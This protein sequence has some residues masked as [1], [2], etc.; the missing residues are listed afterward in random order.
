MQYQVP[1][2]RLIRFA[3]QRGLKK[4]NELD[5]TN[6]ALST[7]GI[8]TKVT[9]TKNTVFAALT[10]GRD[11]I[12]LVARGTLI[13][14]RNAFAKN[15]RVNASGIPFMSGRPESTKESL[16][17]TALTGVVNRQLSYFDEIDL[18]REVAPRFFVGQLCTVLGQTY[19]KNGF[20]RYMPALVTSSLVDP[21]FEALGLRFVGRGADLQLEISP[22]PQ[23]LYAAVTAGQSRVYAQTRLF[24]RAFRDGYTGVDSPIIAAV[25]VDLAED[26]ATIIDLE[27]LVKS[28]VDR[29]NAT[30]KAFFHADILPDSKITVAGSRDHAASDNDITITVRKLKDPIEG[31]YAY[32]AR[33]QVVV[34]F[35]DNEGIIEG[36][37]GYIGGAIRYLWLCFYVERFAQSSSW[38]ILERH[39]IDRS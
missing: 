28:I 5:S 7:T 12:Q 14:D 27:A 23:L 18:R 37:Y 39:S 30:S 21:H 8:I 22:L 34:S 4:F 1:I 19:E 33:E 17:L 24:S 6:P 29:L 2:R 35:P 15:T 11:T 38:R 31:E 26:D 3:Q 36:H 13:A 16:F 20:M 10:D 9:F 32:D 25:D